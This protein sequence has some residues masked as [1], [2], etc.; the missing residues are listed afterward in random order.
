MLDLHSPLLSYIMSYH[1]KTTTTAPTVPISP[2]APHIGAPNTVA[3]FSSPFA[4]VAAALA[5]AE[6]GVS[7]STAAVGLRAGIFRST[8][9]VLQRFCVN[10]IVSI[11]ITSRLA[12]KLNKRKKDQARRE[13]AT[14]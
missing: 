13:E 6:V 11:R 1:V 2:A 4:F 9:T 14:Y 10:A 5:V 12:S 7:L 8:P 3:A